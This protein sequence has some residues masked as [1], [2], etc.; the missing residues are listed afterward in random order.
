MTN[1]KTSAIQA[2]DNQQTEAFQKAFILLTV[3][4]LVNKHKC[5][6]EG[7]VRA[8]IFNANSNGL[9]ESKAIVRIGR[10]VLINEAKFFAW[11]EAQNQGVNHD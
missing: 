5:F 8:L 6:T 3:K 10:K 11:V 2:A 1:Q 7:G 9:A 4:Q